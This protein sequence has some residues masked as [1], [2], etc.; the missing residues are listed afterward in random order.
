MVSA[1]VALLVF[2]NQ[3]TAQNTAQIEVV[4]FNWSFY[5]PPKER[6]ASEELNTGIFK[7]AD[8]TNPTGHKTIE[9]RS[10]DLTRTERA[11]VRQ[12]AAAAPK[13]CFYMS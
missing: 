4:K 13:I 3:I 12:A 7:R 1:A 6:I 5:N 11:A 9:E 10:R 2:S 8:R